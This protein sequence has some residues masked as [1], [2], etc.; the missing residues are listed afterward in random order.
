MNILLL[1]AGIGALVV[2]ALHTFVGQSKM[3]IPFLAND[4]DQEQ[5]LVMLANYFVVAVV[6]LGSGVVLFLGG[7]GTSISDD[8]LTFVSSAWILF[9]MI[10]LAI[11]LFVARPAGLLRLP[12]WTLLIPIGVLGL[13]GVIV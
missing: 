9:G 3:V 4:I 1:I 10:F 5:K 6:L 11:S 13:L 12:Q 7:I 8:L 2:F